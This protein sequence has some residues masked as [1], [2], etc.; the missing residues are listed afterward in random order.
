MQP[1]SRVLALGLALLLAVPAAGAAAAEHEAPVQPPAV[2]APETPDPAPATPAP[3]APERPTKTFTGRLQP[4]PGTTPG[5]APADAPGPDVGARST[6]AAHW[7]VLGYAA[8]GG[9]TA[10]LR[11]VDGVHRQG[12][13]EMIAPTG[14]RFVSA[15]VNNAGATVFEFHDDGRRIVSTGEQPVWGSGDIR[16]HV[17]LEVDP[18]V[19]PGTELAD[20]VVRVRDATGVLAEGRVVVVTGRAPVVTEPPQ[21][22]PLLVGTTGTMRAAGTGDGT[23][24]VRW[25][26]SLDGGA[27][28]SSLFWAGSSSW[29]LPLP[30]ATPADDRSQ[31]RVRV[32]SEFGTVDSA[33]ALLRVVSAPTVVED[34]AHA[35]VRWGERARFSAASDRTDDETTVR[36][37]V[38]RGAGAAWQDLPGETSGTLTTAPA[39]SD[40]DG[41]EYRAVFRTAVGDVSAETPTAVARLTLLPPPAIVEQPADAWVTAGETATFRVAAS[42]VDPDWAPQW[43]RSTDGGTTWE[44]VAG[45]LG[46]THELTQTTAEMSG[47]LYRV[48]YDAHGEPASSDAARLVVEIE[49]ELSAGPEDRTVVAGEVAEFTARYQAFTPGTSRLWQRSTD[50][51]DTWETFSVGGCAVG[52]V[53]APT[54]PV[55]P[56]DLAMDGDLYRLVLSYLDGRRT[57]E[58]DAARLTVLPPEAPVVTSH[59]QDVPVLEGQPATFTAEATGLPAPTVQWQVSVAGGPWTDVPGAQDRT[60]VLDP[61]TRDLDQNRYRAVFTSTAGQTLVGSAT[62]RAATLT[63]GSVRPLHLQVVP[64]VELVRSLPTAP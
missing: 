57:V 8:P 61:A 59:P 15:T 43:Q 20:G 39:T 17:V 24:A 10:T 51:G 28:W 5:T 62:S 42:G 46:T 22:V 56:V 55:G 50:G 25:Q 44:D 63:V 58:S 52:A 31:F 14:A 40:M 30:A 54:I 41:W 19:V 32:T 49:P 60:L 35:E 33:P 3:E 36:W 11:V 7:D 47:D 48:R 38:L 9:R 37:Q 18:D 4:G 2:P 12:V 16:A 45:A 6:P 29:E 1:F 13:K 26:R 34:P 23:L 27:T 21:M 64:R 53:C